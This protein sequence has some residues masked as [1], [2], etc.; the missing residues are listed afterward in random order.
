MFFLGVLSGFGEG[1]WVGLFEVF[2]L[3]LF[4]TEHCLNVS[5]VG[6]KDS[7]HI[8]IYKYNTCIHVYCALGSVQDFWKDS[9][10]TPKWYVK[11][12]LPPQPPGPPPW[13]EP[14]GLHCTQILAMLKGQEIKAPM[15]PASKPP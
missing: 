4:Q 10:A 2:V 8:Y 3:W 15:K 11:T 5:L 12:W 13:R 14:A 1:V 6:L 9:Q 7:C